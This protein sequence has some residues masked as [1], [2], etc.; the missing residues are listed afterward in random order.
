ML[1]WIQDAAMLGIRAAGITT[2]EKTVALVEEAHNQLLEEQLVRAVV[3]GAPGIHFVDKKLSTFWLEDGNPIWEAA[4][5]LTEGTGVAATDWIAEQITTQLVVPARRDT[6]QQI[7]EAAPGFQWLDKERNWFWLGDRP[8]SRSRLANLVSKALAVSG[9]LAAEDLRTAV[10]RHHRTSGVVPPS[11]ALTSFCRD[12]LGYAVQGGEIIAPL[13]LQPGDVLQGAEATFFDILS[14]NGRI[15][16]REQ[17]EQL[18]LAQGMPRATFYVYLGNSPILVRH[19]RGVYGLVGSKITDDALAML[20]H[21][22]RR[23]G[24]SLND[25]GTLPDGKVWLSYSVTDNMVERGVFSVP[26]PLSNQLTGEFPLSMED[27]TRVGSIAFRD[28]GTGIH[29]FLRRTGGEP[30]DTLM[31]AVDL[32][33]RTVIASLGSPELVEDLLEQQSDGQFS[34]YV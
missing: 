24:R 22:A 34:K 2:I 8:R 27:G 28:H 10:R 21:D 7:L 5:D 32:E 17:M 12:V 15:M 20:A 16:T 30:G 26:A 4:T 31:L 14:T 3:S 1:G 23:R 29:T 33:I 19:H 13:D 18:C 11:I 6:V 25:Y 9:Q